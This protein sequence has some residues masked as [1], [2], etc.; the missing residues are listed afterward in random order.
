MTLTT[1]LAIAMIAL[2]AIAVSAVGWL[3]YRSLE[4]TILPRVLDRIEIQ[5]RLA[6]S[7]F[8]APVRTGRGDIAT[9]HGLAAVTGLMRARL[10]G[11]IDPTDGTTEAIWRERLQGRLIA[12]MPLR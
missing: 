5:S 12:Q 2:V 9:F 10:N 4:Q 7:E 11:G 8:G 1:R 3:S 6:A